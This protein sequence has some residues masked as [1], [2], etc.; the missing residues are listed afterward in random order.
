[1]TDLPIPSAGD[2]KIA[3]MW[4]PQNWSL[5]TFG[6]EI[7]VGVLSCFHPITKQRLLN[8][9]EIPPNIKPHHIKASTDGLDVVW[10]DSG[11]NYHS[12]FYPWSW[13][14]AHTYDPPLKSRSTLCEK[15][16][17][18]ANSDQG[19]YK[20]LSDIDRFGFCLVSGVPATPEATEELTKR[21]GFIRET[22]CKCIIFLFWSGDTAY[23]TMAL[24]AHTDNTYFTDPC[25]LQLFHLLSHT[26][27][28]GGATLLVDGFYVAS[29]L[30]KLHPDAYELLSRIPIP[31]HAAGEATALYRPSP[32]SGYPP[33]RHDVNGELVQVRWNNDDRSVMDHV[34]VDLVE[35]WYDAIRTW[36][37]LLTSAD[38]EYWVQLT[39]GTVLS[40]DNH[41][42]LHGRS[43]FDGKRRVCGAY[44]G[45]DE[46]RSRLAVLRERVERHVRSL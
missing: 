37:A 35:S 34:D 39:P 28:S 16:L 32:P 44:V 20:W 6:C 41:R 12:S 29:L 40:V 18:G 3:I 43:T 19:L 22:Q 17:W 15:A 7:T 33:L 30:K 38:S 2:R 25:G 23:T 9:F 31:A 10:P 21:I 14:K 45:M 8:T 1:M 13:L 24:G 46:Y 36:H 4:T 5:I 26:E 11:T 27:G 42:V